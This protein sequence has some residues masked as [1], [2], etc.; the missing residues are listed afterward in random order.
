MR[1]IPISQIL[2]IV[3]FTLPWLNPF[4]FGPTPAIASLIFSWFC[5]GAAGMG[6][7]LSD[8]GRDRR[9][10]V[11]II[12]AAW[13]LAALISVFLGLLQ[14]FGKSDLFNPWV[15]V[16]TPGIAYGNL[17]QRN[18]FATLTNIGLAA[19]IGW[20]ASTATA[21]TWQW[22]VYAWAAVLAVG[23]AASSSR[24]GFTQL[25]LFAGLAALWMA[26][27]RRNGARQEKR[28][29]LV[30]V[31]CGTYAIA[32]WALPLVG[33]LDPQS[34]G[35]LGRLLEDVSLCS[36]RITLW[37]NVLQLIGQQPW[38]GW[39]WGQLDYAH[40]LTIYPGAR[41]CDLLD[42]AHN[43]PLHWAVELGVPVA[44]VLSGLVLWQII[45]AKPWRETSATAQMAWS[46]LAVV[47][48]HSLLEYPLWYGPFQLSV[49]LSVYILWCTP[50][51]A[52]GICE[53]RDARPSRISLAVA[54][55]ATCLLVACT[56][57]AWDYWRVS[58]LYLPLAERSRGYRDDT[59][60]K[61]QGTVLFQDQVLFAEMTTTP[62]TGHSAER[63]N[64]LAKQLL[65]FSPE[66]RV[67]EMLIESAVMLGRDDEALF[68]LQR[69]KAAYPEAHAKWA[70]P[71]GSH[72]TP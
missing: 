56:Y 61:V 15:N 26:G 5:A 8:W 12:A 10:I 18:Q 40:F 36:S 41:F 24:T 31:A 19:L 58:Q 55:A 14:Y 38:S 67:V 52:G 68:Y 2:V 50:L 39:G 17:R 7:A 42:N 20:G 60:E 27:N 47:G 53:M 66:P 35:I 72:K 23:N 49:G 71:S 51:S 28:F 9:R 29:R 16:T 48:L 21:R 62:L 59:L 46:V 4:S 3:L 25:L 1:G 37:S 11:H 64:A 70:N 45:R 65:H 63:L 43:L 13:V 57:A 54:L 30:G 44:L 32:V 33:G 6:I 69:F 34:T 22:V